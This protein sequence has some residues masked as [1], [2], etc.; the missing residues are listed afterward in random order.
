[1]PG[2]CV[3]VVVRLGYDGVQPAVVT[4]LE[5]APQAGLVL[6]E[7]LGAGGGAGPGAGYG[8]GYYGR[9]PAGPLGGVGALALPATLQ[10]GG[11]LTASFLLARA[12]ALGGVA[13]GGGGGAAGAASGGGLR[14]GN[15]GLDGLAQGAGGGG[16]LLPAGAAAAVAAGV[17][18]AGAEDHC[19]LALGYVVLGE[20][21]VAQ[22]AEELL[23]PALQPL[24]GGPLPLPPPLAGGPGGHVGTAAATPGAATGTGLAA[25]PLGSAAH[26]LYGPGRGMGVPGMGSVAEE[27]APGPGSGTG[28][29]LGLGGGRGASG[30]QV[31]QLQIG[32]GVSPGV[33]SPRYSIALTAGS[34]GHAS[35]ARGPSL[36]P[37]GYLAAGVGAG[38]VGPGGV[39]GAGGAPGPLLSFTLPFLLEFPAHAGGGLD[40]PGGGANLVAVALLGPFS[41]W[42]LGQPQA[43]TWRITRVGGPPA[44]QGAIGGAG[45]A[46]AEGAE[47][48]GAAGLAGE[49]ELGAVRGPSG[50]GPSGVSPA[51]AAAAVGAGA[52]EAVVYEVVEAEGEP[53]G[54][55]RLAVG[56]RGVVR[57]GCA[58]GSVAMVE[59]VVAPL[60][61]GLLA[62]PRLSLHNVHCS[63]AAPDPLVPV[64]VGPGFR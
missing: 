2:G 50:H 1:M 54:Q 42:A 53:A 34:T 59:A 47:A 62:P 41:G 14:G 11:R 57:L 36:G 31:L 58:R 51:A 35:L 27:E 52:S 38:L 64:G 25:G 40:G 29:G 37:A 33:L 18:A 63:K 61:A 60:C 22:G 20:G 48:A 10:R 26:S 5:L 8:P 13:G 16:E 56:C 44:L 3:L 55:W 17:Y 15:G 49:Q 6:A 46:G 45:G 32:D 4:E 24:W 21:A 12:S 28:L 39:G 30:E 7:A 9:G 23:G 43:L 19:R